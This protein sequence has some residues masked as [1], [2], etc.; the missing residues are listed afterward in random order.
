M[1]STFSVTDPNAEYSRR[2]EVRRAEAARLSRLD[3]TIGNV[4]LLTVLVGVGIW[5]FVVKP[6]LL[7]IWWLVLPVIVFIG[8]VFYHERV[9]Q[10]LRL[11][12]RGAAFYE[13]GIARLE[14][15]WSGQGEP[16]TDFLDSKHP[17]AQD[18][19]LFGPGSLFELLCAARTRGGECILAEWLRTPAS[20]E[21]IRARQEAIEELRAKLDLREQLALRGEEMRAGVHPQQLV[22]WAEAPVLLD[23]Q[24][25]RVVA[26]TLVGLTVT[27]LGGWADFGLS[28]LCVLVA[29]GVQGIFAFRLRTRV[30]Q[31]ISGVAPAN[32][33]LRLLAEVLAC[34][35]A[36]H[37]TCPRLAALRT[38]LE[39]RGA[40]PS[41]QIERL[42]RLINLLESRNNQLFIPIA[43]LLLWTTQIALAI[44]AWRNVSGPAVA[45]WLTAIGELEAL[46]SLAG[47]AYEHP[48]DPF[49]EIVGEG[50]RF[51]GEGLGHPLIP[52]AHCVRNDVHLG[53]PVCVLIVSGS[54]MSG[55]STLLRT[56]GIN[57]VLALAGAPVRARQLRIS[58][59]ALGATVRIL[60]SLQAGSSHFYAEITRLRVLMDLA[61]GPRPL[62]FLLDEIFHGTNSHDRQI[63]AAAIIR[64][65]LNRGAIGL[66]TTHDLAL[67]RVAD[68]LAPQ[69]ANVYF[70]DQLENG[71]LVFDYC[72][73]PGV[74]QKSNALALMRAI[75]LE[76]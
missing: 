44:E 1:K 13:R 23:L 21:E 38:A 52:E 61:R 55:K 73:R 46:C 30:L 36:E 39:T 12:Q 57:A 25:E 31:V 56:V 76:V 74:V 16:G 35:E 28:S 45:R 24:R 75:G 11:A 9:R 17:Y 14:D 33:D 70:E 15:R 43:A 37:F 34:F 65:F 4:R 6:G 7:T 54:N 64:G 26:V 51:A 32:R 5:W 53:D 42:G 3:Q 22:T 62:L 63:G 49:P 66:V 59:L 71:Q 40:P 18:L 60:D 68:S 58:P 29:L 10:A 69:A 2:L 67:T 48:A 27:M 41:Q 19:D 8:L 72:M 50:P 20:L 47:Y